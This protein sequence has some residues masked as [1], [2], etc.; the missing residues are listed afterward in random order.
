[1]MQLNLTK[2][3]QISTFSFSHTHLQLMK[4]IYHQQNTFSFCKFSSFISNRG[5]NIC[6]HFPDYRSRVE[7]TILFD[8]DSS[9]NGPV[10]LS[11]AENYMLEDLLIPKFSSTSAKI[12]FPS[13]L[14]YYQHGSGRLE[15]RKAFASYMNRIVSRGEYMFQ[16]EN[17]VLGSELH[18]FWKISFL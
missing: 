1:M 6:V 18:Q 3:S 12:G 15:L 13:D 2:C 17:L 10:D 5:Q 11:I 8:P 16:A 14:I 4:L 7:N 9:P